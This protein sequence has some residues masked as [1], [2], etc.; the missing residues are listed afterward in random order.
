MKIIINIRDDIEHSVAMQ[1]V[2]KVIDQGFV[3]DEKQYCRATVFTKFTNPVINK[4]IVVHAKKTRG[5]TH[6]FVVYK[7]V[8][9]NL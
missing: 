2:K 1:V 5:D 6:S 9:N 8:N 7:D 4:P 3:S